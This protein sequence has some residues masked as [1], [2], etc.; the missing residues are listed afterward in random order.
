M[1]GL[2]EAYEEHSTPADLAAE[3]AEILS[4]TDEQI[5]EWLKAH[6][7]DF[8]ASTAATQEAMIAGWQETL[9]AMNG[10]QETNWAEVEQIMAGGQEAIIQFLRE[11]LDDYRLASK[12]QAEAYEEEWVKVL[13][14][15]KAQMQSFQET[16]TLNPGEVLQPTV[17]QPS[18]SSGS[19]GGSGGKTSSSGGGKKNN[20]TSS[21]TSSTSL[22]GLLAGAAATITGAIAGATVAGTVGSVIGAATAAI[23]SA[24]ANSV[25][26]VTSIT[27]TISNL[28]GGNTNKKS[29]SSTTNNSVTVNVNAST[30]KSTANTIK[31]VVKKNGITMTLK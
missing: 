19:S 20:S 5:I 30:V 22:A 24:I 13:D 2:D 10:I 17:I 7:E 25:K 28:F 31:N 8:A 15:L 3:V 6:S 14:R 1:A 23:G 16:V 4:M 27:N 11:N 21:S 29:S 18:T 26:P 9:N 12:E